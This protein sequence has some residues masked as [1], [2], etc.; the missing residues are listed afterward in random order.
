MTINIYN[1][2]IY[3]RRATPGTS[4]STL[5]IYLS[6]LFHIIYIYKEIILEREIN[7]FYAIVH[8]RIQ[9]AHMFKL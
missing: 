1:I 2:F 5:Y 8:T 3:I 6:H 4:A 9:Y 7:I